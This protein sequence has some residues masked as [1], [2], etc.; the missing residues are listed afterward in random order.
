MHCSKEMLAIA[1]VI[2]VPMIYVRPKDQQRQA[3]EARAKFVHVDG[4]H[5]SLL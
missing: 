1:A 4:D 5:L 3:D 2:S